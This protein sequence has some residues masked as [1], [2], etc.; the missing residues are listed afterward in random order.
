MDTVQQVESQLIMRHYDGF[1]KKTRIRGRRGSRRQ[2]A[3]MALNLIMLGPPGAGKGT[4]AERFAQARGMP[5]ISTGDILREAVQ[6]G[7]RARR[8]APRRSWTRGELVERR[9]DDRDRARAAGRGRMRAAGS[10][11]TGFRGR[12]RRRRRSTGSWTDR[13]PLIVVDIVV[14]E[15]E[16]VR[17]LGTRMIC[18]DCGT[19]A[20]R[21]A[22]R[23]GAACAKCGGR[24]VQRA[25]DNEA[26]VLERL[27]VYH[28]QTEAARRLLPGAADVPLD[29]RRAGAR[30]RG[31]GSGGGDRGGRQ[32]RGREGAR[33]VIV[34]RS[35]AELERMRE[36]GRLVGEVLDRAGGARSRRA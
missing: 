13:D 4:Q 26:I 25:D 5:K 29:R 34:C 21:S 3:S 7:T 12:W 8:S 23:V 33:A 14:P 32:R 20:R 31:G 24:L 22:A 11:S 9:R 17:R 30:S 35:A 6:A 19:T 15:D 36:A 16:L 27:K 28:R 2:R 10:C 18:D 1:M